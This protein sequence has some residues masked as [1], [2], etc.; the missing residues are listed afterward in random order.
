MYVPDLNGMPDE[1]KGLAGY[2][3]EGRWRNELVSEKADYFS[4]LVIYLSLKA[5]AKKPS[6]WTELKIEDSETLLFSGDDIKSKGTT[7]IFHELKND[8][9]LAELTQ[10]LCEFMCKSS[11]EE[12]EPLER[13]IISLSDII[14]AKWGGG[15]GYI[16]TCKI[17]DSRK[18]SEKW[19]KGNGYVKPDIEDERKRLSTSISEKFKKPE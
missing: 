7:E 15:N 6:L 3:H 18:I 12:L 10:K 8:S 5:L 4:E 16:P 13:A 17:D 1:I 9:D 19:G 11:I 2:Q 14:S